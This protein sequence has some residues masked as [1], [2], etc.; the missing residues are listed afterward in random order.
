MFAL[1]EE[2]NIRDFFCFG[3]FELKN[4]QLQ[5]N[6]GKLK[7]HKLSVFISIIRMKETLLKGLKVGLFLLETEKA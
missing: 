6:L 5:W 1:L 4:L 3:F 2:E 7:I